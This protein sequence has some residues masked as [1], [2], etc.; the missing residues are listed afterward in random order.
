[1]G[2]NVYIEPK[3]LV[4]V[5]TGEPDATRI[6][7]T[8]LRAQKRYTSSMAIIEATLALSRPEKFNIP[9]QTAEALIY[10]FLENRLIETID[11]PGAK[12]ATRTALLACEKFNNA[13]H[14]LNMA[15][16]TH[17]TIA[18]YWRAAMLVVGNEYNHTDLEIA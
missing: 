1:M 15:E 11:N 16:L 18:K 12:R 9:L 4:A 13:S 3:A 5:L 7:D 14:R 8:L 6:S 2:I 17:Y 10:D